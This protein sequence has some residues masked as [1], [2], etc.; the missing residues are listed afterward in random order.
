MEEISLEKIIDF[1]TPVFDLIQAYPEVQEMMLELGF[2]DLKNPA[3]LNTV[4]RYV[5]LNKGARLKKISVDKM[6]AYFKEHGFEVE[7]I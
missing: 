2:K 7:G 3:L 4:G 6:I 1:N 5:T